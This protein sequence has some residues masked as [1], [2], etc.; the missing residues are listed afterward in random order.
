MDHVPSESPASIRAISARVQA[1]QMKVT[2][3]SGACSVLQARPR[4][5][6]AVRRRPQ[7]GQGGSTVSTA[8]WE[9]ASIHRGWP[10]AVWATIELA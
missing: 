3:P 7:P 9:W 5:S 6:S 8:T 1:G 2:V 10:S 4:E